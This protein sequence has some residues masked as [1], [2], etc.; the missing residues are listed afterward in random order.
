MDFPIILLAAGASSRMRGRDKLMQDVAGQPLLQ[1]SAGRARA[2]TTGTVL[3]ALPPQPHPRYA[4]LAG[5]DVTPI[6]VPDAGE[7]MNASLRTAVAALPAT[8]SAAMVLLADLP[9][10][11]SQDLCTLGHAVDL[12]SPTQVWRA[13]TQDGK[14]GHPT[15]FAAALF[16][17]LRALTGDTGA[18][19]V[20]QMAQEHVAHIP[21]P[22]TRARRD[23][24]TPEA[25]ALWRAEQAQRP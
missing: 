17:S 4:T 8:A 21:L 12:A 15:V 1:R 22:G 6:P 9:D 14:P 23:L 7:G 25:W 18:R 10:L 20:I 19:D 2:A 13:T 5:M 3:V 11:T 16:E 24:D